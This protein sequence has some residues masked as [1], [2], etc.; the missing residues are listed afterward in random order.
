MVMCTLKVLFLNF[1]F[2]YLSFCILTN[3]LL[4][5]SSGLQKLK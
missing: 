2:L 3:A 4:S 5:V 1:I